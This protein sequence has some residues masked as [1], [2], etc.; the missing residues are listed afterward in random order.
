MGAMV[1]PIC[2]CGAD[3]DC[4]SIGASMF[5]DVRRV[6]AVCDTG[7]TF[8]SVLEHGD[9]TCPHCASALRV[10]EPDDGDRLVWCPQCGQ[11][12]VRFVVVAFGD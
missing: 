5:S 9:H 3:F 11:R 12:S 4:I 8:T 1:Q 6:A 10:V 7:R 2:D